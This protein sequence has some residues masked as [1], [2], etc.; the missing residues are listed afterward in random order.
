MTDRSARAAGLL[1]LCAVLAAALAMGL[2]Q[3]FGLF[4]APMTTEHG[5]TAFGFASAIGL[6]V[7]LN[8]AFQPFCGQLADRFGGRWVVMGGALA[9]AL[10]ILGMALSSDIAVF[11]FFAGVVMGF[12]VSSA[13]MPV[14]IA[15]L[16][17]LLPESSR[18]RAVGLGT[19]GS[20][21]GQFLV[22]PVAGFGLATLGWQTTLWLMAAAALLMIPLALP[23]ADRPAPKSARRRRRRR[24]LSSAP[25]AR[26]PSGSCSSASSS[27]ACMSP[28]SPSTCPASCTAAAC[29]WR[30]APGR[31]A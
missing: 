5:W 23:L 24:R 13:G 31:S 8:G 26:P 9:Y 22:V 20:S 19:A 14:I 12:A 30:W 18:G 11:T 2:R 6:Q 17:R 1:M 7:L 21:F 28:S 15:S 4:L 10:G 29:R 3:S 16:T 25:S 27:A